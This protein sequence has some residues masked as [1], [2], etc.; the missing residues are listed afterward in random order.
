M[1]GN[2]NQGALRLATPPR[3]GAAKRTTRAANARQL[4]TAPVEY[5]NRI[6]NYARKIRQTEDVRA[7]IALL[8]EALNETRALHTANEMAMVRKQVVLAE[9]RI[10]RKSVV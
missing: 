6:E 7:I 3:A 4:A 9:Q 2:M 5:Y 1:A 8:D 10:D